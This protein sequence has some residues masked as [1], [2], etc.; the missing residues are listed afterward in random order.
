VFARPTGTVV[1]KGTSR[2]MGRMQGR[3]ERLG[4]IATTPGREDGRLSANAS[5]GWRRLLCAL[6]SVR[7]CR[8][9]NDPSNPG[10]IRF[11]GYDVIGVTT[12]TVGANAKERT[13]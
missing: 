9:S 4:F 13:R 10:R 12:S 1:G 5:G 3:E 11:K 8:L 2:S 6:F 7:D